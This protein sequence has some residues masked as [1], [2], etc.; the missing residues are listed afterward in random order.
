MRPTQ[1]GKAFHLSVLLTCSVL[2]MPATAQ[3]T[4][5]YTEPDVL[6]RNG[7]EWFEKNNYAAARQEFLQYLDRKKPITNISDQNAV[8]AEYYIALTGL[9]LDIP[10]AEV[11]VD[12]FVKTHREH[13]KAGLLYGDLGKYYFDK[14]DYDRAITFLE[15]AIKQSQNANGQAESKYLLA[16]AYYSKQDLRAALPLLNQIKQDPG[17]EQAASASYYAGVINFRQGNY[18]AAMADFKRIEKNPTYQ[19]EIPNWMVQSMYKAGRY[20]DLLAYA[21]PLLQRNRGNAAQLAEVALFTAEVLYKKG[22][23]AK[24][25]PY[26]KQY[27]NIKGR[28][29]PP[30]VQFRYG[31]ALFKTGDYTGAIAALKNVSAGKDTIAQYSAYRLGI[32]YLQTANPTFALNAFDQSARLNFNKPIQEE[33]AFN[34]AK[35]QLDLNNGGDAVKEFTDFLKRYPDSKFENESNELLSEAYFSSNNNAA[36]ISYIEGLKRRTPR[37]NASY[38]RITY[39]QAVT[40]FNAERYDQAIANFDKSLKYPVDSDLRNNALFWK[41]ETFSAMRKYD[42]AIPLYQQAMRSGNVSGDLQ[43]KSLYALGYAS[44]NKKNYPQAITYFRDF[45][46]KS[47]S[48]DKQALEDATVRVADSYFATKNYNE[49]MRFYDN[50]IAQGRIDR[51]YATFQKGLILAFMER[52]VEA[53]AQFEKV[54]TQFPNSRYADDALF[55]MANVDF[56]KGAYQQSIR[57]F[58]R[59]INDKPKSYLIPAALL[60]R[61]TANTNLQV[62]EPA[63]QDY[64]RILDQFG[65]SPSAPGALLGLQNA[66]SDAGRS[67]EFSSTLSS[68]KKNNPGSTDVQKVEYENAKSLYFNEKYAQAV[69]TLLGFIDDNPGSPLVYEARYYL[70][71]SYFRSGDLPNALRYYYLVISDNK[72]DFVTRAAA[73]AAEVERQQKNY[74]RAIRNYRTVL[75]QSKSKNE[76]S[77]AVLGLMDTYYETGNYDSTQVS[78]REVLSMG[79]VVPGAQNRAQLMLGKVAYAKGDFKQATTEFDKTIALAKDEQGAEANYWIA[80]ILYR[81]KKHKESIDALLRFNSDFAQYDYW[82]GKG[83]I[84]VADNNVAQ[85][86]IA[87]AKAVLNSII[88]NAENQEIVAEAKQKLAAIESKN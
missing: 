46:S 59:L 41:A 23:F 19:N 71:D 82:K 84:L 87:Q 15:K 78:A 25:I 51:D 47:G 49:A 34:H 9:Y 10:E 70:A 39:N 48:S 21:Q 13:P 6:F 72:S 38:Q 31:D 77:Q 54:L 3:R 40:D 11:Q 14:G 37:I 73:R 75:A 80:D 44:Y 30:A 26:Y 2:A 8:S 36:A 29:V 60:K 88:E 4:L 81:T 63:I 32:S 61:A 45:I 16:M 65:G 17:L 33:S 68:Y 24:A 69:T 67:E 57:G 18:T 52:D 35:L 20:D 28:S 64:K 66:L 55:Q 76:Q 85:N 1:F 42:E 62:Y 43:G 50:A 79:N 27:S 5:S 56:E 22:D 7:L 86:E 58:S 74:P 83:F 53:K 12:R